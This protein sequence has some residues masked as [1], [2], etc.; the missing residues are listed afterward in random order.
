MATTIATEPSASTAPRQPMRP[1]V[2]AAT[3]PTNTVP[4]LPPAT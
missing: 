1:M 4:M 2:S 3:K